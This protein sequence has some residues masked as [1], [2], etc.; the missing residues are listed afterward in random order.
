MGFHFLLKGIS[1]PRTEP[2]SPALQVDPLLTEPPGKPC[3]YV[4]GLRKNALTF[5]RLSD[6]GV[7]HPQKNKGKNL[8]FVYDKKTNDRYRNYKINISSGLALHQFHYLFS[9]ALSHF[10]QMEEARNHRIEDSQV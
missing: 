4:W 5:F 7:N 2:R 1:R 8:W 3:V 10:I 6:E 9:Y